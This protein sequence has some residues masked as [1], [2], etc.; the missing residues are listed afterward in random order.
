MTIDGELP[1]AQASLYKIPLNKVGTITSIEIVNESAAT[2]TA[3]LYINQSGTPR[4]ITPIGFT[5]LAGAK[6]E[7]TMLRQLKGGSSIEGI[8]SGADVS[9][10]IN[11]TLS[12]P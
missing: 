5:L 4:A 12:P 9:F 8:A 11:I 2:R 3:S 1:L 10:V 6:M 7:D